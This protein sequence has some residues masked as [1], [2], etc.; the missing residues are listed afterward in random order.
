MDADLVDTE[1]DIVNGDQQGV[2]IV[3]DFIKVPLLSDHVVCAGELQVARKNNSFY[4]VLQEDTE[5]CVPFEETFFTQ[6][7]NNFLTSCPLHRIF[8]YREIF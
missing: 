6:K 1:D 3:C 5:Y 4:G 7:R 2:Q 8:K